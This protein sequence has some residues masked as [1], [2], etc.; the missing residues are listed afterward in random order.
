MEVKLSVLMF[1]IL[2]NGS[3]VAQNS[4]D[5]SNW[6]NKIASDIENGNDLSIYASE[7]VPD[8]VTLDFI[9]AED[10][11]L[12]RLD[13]AS[14]SLI[15]DHGIGEFC[16]RLV[17]NYSVIDGNYFLIFGDFKIVTF[18]NQEFRIISPWRTKER[19]CP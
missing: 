10:V 13:S 11:Q 2:L 12:E 3:A 14:F 1:A 19:I 16:S 17:F 5:L 6:V 18:E 8:G 4:V 7:S 15:I 9:I